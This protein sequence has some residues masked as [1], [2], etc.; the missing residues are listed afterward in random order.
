MIQEIFLNREGKF[1]CK[2]CLN[3]K[4]RIM[5]LSGIRTKGEKCLINCVNGKEKLI[6]DYPKAVTMVC[7]SNYKESEDEESENKV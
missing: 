7:C 3:W 6:N 1:D 4:D 2:K 5:H